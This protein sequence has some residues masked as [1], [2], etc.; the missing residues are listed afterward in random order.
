MILILKKGEI[1]DRVIC[2]MVEEQLL[3]AFWMDE[4]PIK[5]HLS[6]QGANL[7]T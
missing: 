2:S 1:H 7:L 6:A 4:F 5:M 3:Y